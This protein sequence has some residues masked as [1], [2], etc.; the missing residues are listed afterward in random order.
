MT[1]QLE[2]VESQA[3]V[4]GSVAKTDARVRSGAYFSFSQGVDLVGMKR[5]AIAES[6]KHMVTPRGVWWSKTGN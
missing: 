3:Q 1:N 6:K 4:A 5:A 2:D